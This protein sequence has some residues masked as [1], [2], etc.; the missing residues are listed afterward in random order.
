L[1]DRHIVI[2][3]KTQT[4]NAN[5]IN[6]KKRFDDQDL[7]RILNDTVK[8]SG[9]QSQK[10]SEHSAIQSPGSQKSP[11]GPQAPVHIDKLTKARR[12]YQD[13]GLSQ[14]RSKKNKNK[15]EKQSRPKQPNLKACPSSQIHLQPSNDKLANSMGEMRETYQNYQNQNLDKASDDQQ[16]SQSKTRKQWKDRESFKKQ[17]RNFSPIA[18]TQEDVHFLKEDSPDEQ[19]PRR[20]YDIKQSPSSQ[21][22]FRKS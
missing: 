13:R 22:S 11:S 1:T 8:P 4:E 20:S 17:P 21:L 12:L 18:S 2:Y 9:Q 14:G 10:D 7:A 16:K 5:A 19:L 3:K 15:K 6:G